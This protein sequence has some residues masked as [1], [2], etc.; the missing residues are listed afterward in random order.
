MIF[1]KKL[2]L[3]SFL[4]GA[5]VIIYALTFLLSNENR[6]SRSSRWSALDAKAAD[7]ADT[8]Q[9]TG[10]DAISLVKI[11][12]EW[13][14]K[15]E[16]NNFPARRSKID[17]LL[18]AL[19]RV[20]PYPVR[21][22]SSSSYQKFGLDEES[23]DRILVQEGQLTLLELYLGNADAAGKEIFLRSGGGE[24]RSGEDIFSGFLAGSRSAWYDTRL[25][26]DHDKTGLTVDAV[27]RFRVIPPTG[28]SD[29][30][31]SAFPATTPYSLVRSE[32][33][34]KFDGSDENIDAPTVNAAIRFILD[35]G[36]DDIISCFDPSDPDFSEKN[37]A[38]AR[39][40]LETG[41]G[42]NRV[43]TLGEKVND[44]YSA[45][46]TGSKYIYSLADWTLARLWRDKND[47]LAK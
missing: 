19:T 10:T 40:I 39:I 2:F 41:D 7:S 16:E 43:I 4:A 5:L 1:K 34:W 21:S 37:N 35:C 30:D 27:Q 28:A 44:K 32:E 15:Y 9:I 33:S 38:A 18:S 29:G 6:V 3:L 23:A 42:S 11:N 12:A 46:V 17:D 20:A 26:P 8:I 47:Y 22:S 25:F 24:V 14:V 13:F 45:A 31:A 36:G